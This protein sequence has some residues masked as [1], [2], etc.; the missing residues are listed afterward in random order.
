MENKSLKVPLLLGTWSSLIITLFGIAYMVAIVS[1]LISGNF[2]LPPPDFIQT[3][4]AAVV[5]VISP[6]LIILVFAL[7]F[8][9]SDSKKIFLS[10]E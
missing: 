8:I 5:L 7:Q 6:L 4:A 1:L 9:V 2:R 3:F 10:S